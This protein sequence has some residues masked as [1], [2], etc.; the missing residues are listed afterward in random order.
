MQPYFVPYAGY[1]RLMAACDLVVMFDCV[2]FPRRGWV[3]RNQLTTISGQRD[4]MSL[5]LMKAPQSVL[6]RDLAWSER[7]N[8]KWFYE[9]IQRFP[10]LRIENDLQQILQNFAQ[11]PNIYLMRSIEI[12]CLL[13][14]LKFTPIFSSSLNLPDSLRGEDRILEICDHFRAKT[15]VNVPGGAELYTQDN[16]K[17][18][19]IEL[20]FLPDFIGNYVSIL[21]RLAFE[22]VEK[23]RAE[24]SAQL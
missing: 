6:I 24:I 5:P 22:P 2:Q 16:F 1:F 19:G 10:A 18:R 14:D 15:Y 23:I 4:W 3:H 11:E 8:A 7:A 17:K 12:I 20:K 21:E 13:L 9:Q